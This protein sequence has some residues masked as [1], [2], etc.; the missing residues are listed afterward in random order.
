MLIHAHNLSFSYA[1]QTVLDNISLSLQAGQL[2]GLI[3]PNGA[4]KSTLL[5]L[6]AGLYKPQ[7]GDIQLL[8][9]ALSA[10][11]AMERGRVLAWLEQQGAI[12]WPLSVERLVALGR[13]PHLTSWQ[14]ISAVDEAAIEHTLEAT[15]VLHLRKRS[16]QTLS[17]GERSRVLLARALAGQPRVLL[18]DEPI[19]TLDLAHQLQIMQLLRDIAQGEA[20]VIVVLHDLSLAARYCDQLYLL[21]QGRVVAQGTPP[22]VLTE[23]LLRKVYGV[24]C[25]IQWGYIPSITAL[26]PVP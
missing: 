17:G 6:L 25:A 1:Q 18:A 11:P 9:R 24:E 10:W 22:Q 5:K 12:H 13:L 2:I 19:A 8:G 16:A 23:A 4:S 26:Y 3:G 7:Q 20:G 14:T 15:N 21:Q